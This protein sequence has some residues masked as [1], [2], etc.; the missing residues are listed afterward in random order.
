M[1]DISVTILTKNNGTTLSRAL[2]SLLDFDE[3]LVYD[4]GSTDETIEIAKEFK[5]VK[6]VEGSFIGFGPSHNL[7]SSLAKH[8]WILSLDSDEMLS[9][10]LVA[11]IQNLTKDSNAVYS[12]P[13]HNYYREKFIRGCG[14][15]PDRQYRLYNRNRTAFTPVEVHEQ[16]IVDGC[17]HI[18]LNNPMIHYS[19]SSIEDFLQKMQTYS[20]LF[21]KEHCGKKNSS[22]I[23]AILHG[24]CAFLKSY[25]IKKGFIDGYEG[26]LISFYNGHTAYYKYMKL[27]EANKLFRVL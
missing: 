25:I 23:K 3:V 22:P 10:E 16:I 9:M 15:Y 26:L 24:T 7:A 8:D 5:N 19:Y 21:A 4:N 17:T 27:Y 6:I 1:M 2:K 14:W 18:P 13:R 11:E 20:T 12:F